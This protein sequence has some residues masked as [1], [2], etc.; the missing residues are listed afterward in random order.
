MV[1]SSLVAFPSCPIEGRE[2]TPPRS[3]S[4]HLRGYIAPVP[5]NLSRIPFPSISSSL[6]QP[7]LNMKCFFLWHWL[8]AIHTIESTRDRDNE[9]KWFKVNRFL[10]NLVRW[11]VEKKIYYQ[12]LFKSYRLFLNITSMKSQTM[13]RFNLSVFIWFYDLWLSRND[14]LKVRCWFDDKQD[15]VWDRFSDRFI[16]L[17][18]SRTPSRIKISFCGQKLYTGC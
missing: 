13:S 8:F 18:I 15:D 16:F 1:A 9:R 3:W 2:T 6:F 14:D 5:I 10:I 17:Y 12:K 11:F 7:F 4:T